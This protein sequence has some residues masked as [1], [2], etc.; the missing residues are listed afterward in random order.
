MNDF[1]RGF[2]LGAANNVK[3]TRTVTE[4][5]VSRV[6]QMDMTCQVR[7]ENE[8]EVTDVSLMYTN[9]MVLLRALTWYSTKYYYTSSSSSRSGFVSTSG[10]TFTGYY[11][12]SSSANGYSASILAYNPAIYISADK[13]ALSRDD[14]ALP[15]DAI[16]VSWSTAED[17]TVDD[18]GIST[19]V[20]AYYS[21]DS[22]KA[23]T[24]NKILIVGNIGTSSSSSSSSSSSALLFEELLEDTITIKSGDRF[25]RDYVFR[26]DC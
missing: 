3:V 17:S 23:I 9:N 12:S 22:D 11:S 24:V 20:H 2:I 15:D 8:Q 13:T 14:Y 26:L 19:V 1:D 10:S 7:D 5:Y 21:N 4:M 25:A 6:F 18:S 16:S